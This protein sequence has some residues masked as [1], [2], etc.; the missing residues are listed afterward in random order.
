MAVRSADIVIRQ[1]ACVC[2]TMSQT[3]VPKK[4]IGMYY[5][6]ALNRPNKYRREWHARLSFNGEPVEYHDVFGT[7]AQGI[8]DKAA[9]RAAR[10]NTVLR[11]ADG[12][13]R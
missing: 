5:I 12:D 8:L 4:A 11:V 2:D 13:G 10:R 7:K 9:E 3:T 6:G 1:T